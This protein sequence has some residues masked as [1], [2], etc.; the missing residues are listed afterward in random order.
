MGD[1]VGNS[2]VIQLSAIFG[3]AIVFG[4]LYLI[5]KSFEGFAKGAVKV[6]GGDLKSQKGQDKGFKIFVWLIIGFF[7]LLFM[8]SCLNS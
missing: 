4:V 5:F 8:V 2:I 1:A 3:V 7:L 6:T